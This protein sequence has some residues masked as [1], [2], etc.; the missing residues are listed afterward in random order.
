MRWC[1]RL[2]GYGFAVLAPEIYHRREP[3]GT[4]LGFDDEGKARGQGD[5]ERTPVGDFDADAAAAL[6][7]LGEHSGV[8]SS[9]GLGAA[10]HCT[11]GHLAFRAAFSD[12]VAATACW[13]PTGLHDGK[14]GL[15][16][17]A[18]SLALA[19]EI[20]GE[21]LM[22]FGARD[23][24]TPEPGR[25]AIRS[26]LEQS[27]TSFDWQVVDAEH[28]FGRDIG[29]RY[30]PEA[31]DAAFA[32]TVALYRRCLSGSAASTP[33]RQGIELLWAWLDAVR[34]HD[35]AAV[36]RAMDPSVV[37]HG[38]RE[39][40]VCN[41]AAEVAEMFASGYEAQDIDSVELLGGE[42]HVVLGVRAPDLGE[43]GGV[44]IGSELYNV[45]TLAHGK[46]TRIEDHLER[47]EALAAAGLTP[48]AAS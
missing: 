31:T 29:D 17:D 34:R 36:T 25:E 46:I 43:A 23:P 38:V 20:D 47:S 44:K 39:G 21:L 33:K 8:A 37:W 9:G 3:A 40:L 30:D 45:F 12:N 10:G 2:A 19:G 27:G 48:R 14:L 15:E 16:P 18:G 32:R 42:Q 11:G 4:V 13:Y 22:I 28:A 35:I 24:H 7:Y 26:G 1:V 5:A 6:A 41:G